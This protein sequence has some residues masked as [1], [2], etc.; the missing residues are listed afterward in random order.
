MD[1]ILHTYFTEMSSN[2]KPFQFT[3]STYLIASDDA[4]K[5]TV[6]RHRNKFERENNKKG[7]KNEIHDGQ[8]RDNFL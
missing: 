1:Q 6:E 3:F 4:L 7:N 5:K 2:R 8:T